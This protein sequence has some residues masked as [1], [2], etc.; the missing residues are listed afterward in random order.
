MGSQPQSLSRQE[1]SAG[2]YTVFGDRSGLVGAFSPFDPV[3]PTAG[4]IVK[5][6]MTITEVF[7]P[8]TGDVIQ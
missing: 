1:L 2:N 3:L 7:V 6:T 5:A 4:I 8:Y